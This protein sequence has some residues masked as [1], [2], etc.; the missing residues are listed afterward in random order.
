[1]NQLN[2]AIVS[3]DGGSEEVIKCLAIAFE[4]AL[5]LPV[6]MN[7]LE[8]VNRIQSTICQY[9]DGNIPWSLCIPWLR[10][11]TAINERVSKGGRCT[12]TFRS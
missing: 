3:T 1:M 8:A 5:N 4:S 6:S 11:L 2:L 12:H 10:L 7:A 9:C